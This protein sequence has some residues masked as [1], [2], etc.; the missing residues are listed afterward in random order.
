[1]KA[2]ASILGIGCS[3]FSTKLEASQTSLGADAFLAALD[4][5]GL[6]RDQIDGVSIHYGGPLGIDYDR[7]VS[8]FGL[9]VRYVNQHWRN[10]RFIST[11][12]Q[13]AALAVDAGLAD[14]VACV[15]AISFTR[16]RDQLN[17]AGNAEAVREEGGTHGEAPPY[18]FTFPAGGPALAMQ[19]YMQRFGVTS[20]DLAAVPMAIRAHALRN[21]DA[22]MQKPMGLADYLASLMLSDP[23]RVADCCLVSDGAVVVLIGRPDMARDLKHRPVDIVGMQGLRASREEF[24]FAPRGLGIQQQSGD[25][26]AGRERDMEVYR[27]ARVERADVQGF[28]TYDAFSPLVLFAL[29][30]FGFCGAGEAAS[31]VKDGKIGPGGSLPVNTSGGL[32]SEAHIAGWNSVVEMVRQLRGEAGQRQIADASLLQWGTSWG[33]SILLAN[34]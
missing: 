18:G 7:F 23:L 27:S 21:P 4:D 5:S 14:V 31:F 9:D 24:I 11:A 1:M 12:M 13:N 3:A 26:Q 6:S 28:Y 25:Y 29:E 16:I 30:R 17:A 10:G 15:T 19:L 20:E 34:R 22:I 8:A 32:L 2:R 33:D